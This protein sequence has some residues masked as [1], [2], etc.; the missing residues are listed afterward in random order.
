MEEGHLPVMVEEVMVALS[1]TPGSFHIDATLG[2]GGHTVRILE[3]NAPD[4]RLL[5]LDADQAA[6]ART[7]DRLR[8]FGDRA[9]LRQSNFERIGSVAAENGFREVDGVLFDLGLSSF[10]LDRDDRG[11]SFR[12]DTPLDR[13]VTRDER[14]KSL[15]AP[16]RRRTSLD[17]N[18]AQK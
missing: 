11:F 7:G 14:P 15:L 17:G 12:S 9:V 5:G 1:P 10:Q 6:I 2:G 3:A 8:R 16:F 18:I 4:G 13:A